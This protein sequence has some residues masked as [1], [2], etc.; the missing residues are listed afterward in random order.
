MRVTNNLKDMYLSRDSLNVRY[1]NNFLLFEDFDS[2]L[3]PSSLMNGQFDLAKGTLTKC[4]FFINKEMYPQDI[5]RFFSVE[6]LLRS[7]LINKIIGQVTYIIVVE[8][9]HILKIPCDPTVV[10]I[11]KVFSAIPTQ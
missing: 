9:I 4:L 10:I 1:V 8:V 5:I 3:L 7:L 6:F 2:N 11:E